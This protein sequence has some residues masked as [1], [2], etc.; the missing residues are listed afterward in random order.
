MSE[1]EDGF[2]TET[3]PIRKHVI[4]KLANYLQRSNERSALI[5]K[6]TTRN[7]QL[8]MKEE[9]K[10]DEID[11]FFRGLAITT[12]KF[13]IKGRIKAKKKIFALISE[14]EKYLVSEQPVYT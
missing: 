14:L 9:E 2:S 3:P 13:P 4:S 8:L 10:L 11:M 1:R 6:I 5:K 12:K 7:E